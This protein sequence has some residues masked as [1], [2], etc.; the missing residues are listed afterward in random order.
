[1]ALSGSLLADRCGDRLRTSRV[2]LWLGDGIIHRY[3]Y[4]SHSWIEDR[5][6]ASI[7]I[8]SPEVIPLTEAEA[9]EVIV[10]HGGVWQAPT[11]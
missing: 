4:S 8:G 3:D 1:V 10:R 6:L 11:A 2:V 9:R 5:E 7:F